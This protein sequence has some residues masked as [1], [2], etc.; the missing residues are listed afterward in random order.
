MKRSTLGFALVLM[1]AVVLTGCA[2]KTGVGISYT[3]PAAEAEINTSQDSNG[4]TVVDLRVKH[5]SPPQN[6]SPA[7]S[8]YVAWVETP[9]GRTFNAGRLKINDNLEGQVRVVT[10]YP[11]FRLI[12]SAED[13]PLVIE[14]GYQRVMETEQIEIQ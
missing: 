9:D 12:I 4:N 11:R 13:D 14:P 8:M 5:L 6:L 2:Q 1:L 10:P 3:V 7:R